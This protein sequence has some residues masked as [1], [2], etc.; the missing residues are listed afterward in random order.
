MPDSSSRARPLLRHVLWPAL[1]L[2]WC[3]LIWLASDQP[4]LRIS[5]DHLLDLVLRKSAHLAVFGVL[6]A[7]LLKLLRDWRVEPL[8]AAAGAVTLATAYAAVDEWH[9]TWVPGRV[10]DPADVLIDAAGALAAVLLLHRVGR[11][12]G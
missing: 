2:A 10:G 7:L 5:D 6:A 4:D 11:A 1:V 3:G 8:R 9:Q 12:D